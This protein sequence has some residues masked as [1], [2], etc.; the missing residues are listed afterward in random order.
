[1]L[2]ELR[3]DRGAVGMDLRAEGRRPEARAEGIPD[4]ARVE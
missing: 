3:R 1:M 2:F 4:E